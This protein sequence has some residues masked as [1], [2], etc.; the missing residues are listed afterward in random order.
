MK[1]EIINYL[2][3]ANILLLL[4]GAVYYM[5]LH[6][7]HT[8]KLKRYFL[9]LSTMSALLIPL[10]QIALPAVESSILSTGIPTIILEPFSI[11]QT[12][13]TATFS[14][15]RMI[16]YTLVAYLI[17]A[18]IILGTFLY[19][20]IDLWKIKKIK[21]NK[22]AKKNGCTIITTNK[23]Y[24]SFSF[25]NL[26]FLNQ[27]ETKIEQDRQKIIAHELVHAQQYHSIDMM[28]LMISRIIFWVNPVV[29][30]YKRSQQETHE[31]LVDHEVL[32]TNQKEDYQSLLARITVNRHYSTGNYF[33]QNQTI[34][35]IN[36]MNEKPKKHQLARSAFA[37]LCMLSLITFLAC[38]DE[39]V[40]MLDSAEQ[41]LE[42]PLSAQ[43]ELDQLRIGYPDEIFNYIEV[44][45]PTDGTTVESA[46]VGVKNI[47]FIEVDKT[48]NKAGLIVAAGDDFEKLVEYRKTED[49]FDIVETQPE[50]K[51]GMEEFY[52]YI[53]Q[54]M[55]YP[56]EAKIAGIEGRVFVQFII[57][58]EGELT[59]VQVVKGIGH[60]CDQEAIRVMEQASNWTPGQQKGEA[61]KVRMILPITYQL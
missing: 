2:L 38:N 13:A 28:L 48:R 29:W 52:K 45:L 16:N 9:L 46:L 26:I 34:K 7:Q 31:Y 15:D 39:V 44:N 1:I 58:E 22:I 55:K 37:I 6:N 43:N 47:Q 42:I 41:T 14:W 12:N 40:S 49:V 59:N 17:I 8:F 23:P 50:P 32:K 56:K 53:G 20:L 60:G 36:M 61:V 35:R 33:A 18:S 30:H 19:Q 27:E 4:S 3:E 57:D 11:E 5:L 24:P 21:S 51:G 25:F 10:I 54:N